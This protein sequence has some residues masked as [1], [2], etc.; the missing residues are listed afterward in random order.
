MLKLDNKIKL[1]QEE[2]AE[3]DN[4]DIK[5]ENFKLRQRPQT[6]SANIQF[7]SR[8]QFGQLFPTPGYNHYHKTLLL[9]ASASDK[10]NY[11]IKTALVSAKKDQ[12]PVTAITS[13][14]YSRD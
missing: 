8:S 9:D 14:T 6:A 4:V 10:R 2:E 3:E 1:K 11:R 12:P 7:N 13:P 5:R